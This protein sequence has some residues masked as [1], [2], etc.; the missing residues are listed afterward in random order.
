[1]SA[2][3]CSLAFPKLVIGNNNGTCS[4]QA[5]VKVVTA[6]IIAKASFSAVS[7]LTCE[8]VQ[9]LRRIGHDSLGTWV[10]QLTTSD[11]VG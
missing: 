6:H 7:H 11:V 9:M 8:F 3:F 4:V 10:T 1:M 5:V 2:P